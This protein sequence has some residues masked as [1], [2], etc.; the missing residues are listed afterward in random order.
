[1]PST[2]TSSRMAAAV[3]LKEALPSL[4][5]PIVTYLDRYIQDAGEDPS[6]DVMRDVVHPMLESAV[7]CEPHDSANRKA[8]PALL[9]KLGAMVAE[10]V[11]TVLSRNDR[12]LTRLDKVVDMGAVEM[13]STITYDAGNDSMDLALGR[14]S[15][16][17]TTVDVKKLEKQEAKT[18]AKLAKRAQRDL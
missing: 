16:N 8:L 18:R 5:E 3:L 15:R 10:R 11:P 2:K 9:E 12:G 13:S 1:M 7:I 14:S 6:V 4:D 17:R